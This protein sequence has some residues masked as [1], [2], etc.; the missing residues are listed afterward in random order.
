MLME[1]FA[2]IAGF[3]EETGNDLLVLEALANRVRD[4]ETGYVQIDALRAELAKHKNTRTDSETPK[5]KL[6]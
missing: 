2:I 1:H 5:M 4:P 6:Q 3:L